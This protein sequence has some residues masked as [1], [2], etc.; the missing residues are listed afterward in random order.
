[1]ITEDDLM[2]ELRQLHEANHPPLQPGEFTI[3]QYADAQVPP[4]D[5]RKAS[6]A[7]DYLV[8]SGR[9]IRLSEQR[10]YNGK[11]RTTF[12]LIPAPAPKR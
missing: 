5:Y 7:C 3:Q 8:A 12:K 10:W 4:I 1:M 11:L 9:A 6:A 2:A